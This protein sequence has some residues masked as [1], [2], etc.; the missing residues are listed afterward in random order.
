MP[1]LYNSAFTSKDLDVLRRALDAWCAEK[2][3]DIGSVEAQSAASA[4]L[5]LY[6]S[7]YNDHDKLLAALRDRKGL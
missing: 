5:D 6:Q 3:V 1:F 4:A 7:G 2:H